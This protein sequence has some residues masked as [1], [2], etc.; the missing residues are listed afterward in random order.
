ML[1]LNWC[2]TQCW[3]HIL[4]LPVYFNLFI[5]HF[6]RKT[7]HNINWDSATYLTHSTDKY[8]TYTW[9]LVNLTHLTAPE[10]CQRLTKDFCKANTALPMKTPTDFDKYV[11]TA[12]YFTR[13]IRVTNLLTPTI[14]NKTEWRL[15][16]IRDKRPFLQSTRRFADEN[17]D[18]LYLLRDCRLVSGI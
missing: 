16:T 5:I 10:S 6:H 8:Q 15:W 17:T 12:Y 3:R 2:M 7:G 4:I 13:T 11:T 9:K 14:T 18:W 1:Q